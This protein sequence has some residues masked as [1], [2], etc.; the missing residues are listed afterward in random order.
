MLSDRSIYYPLVEIFKVHLLRHLA[1][2]F[3]H[4]VNNNSHI[5]LPINFLYMIKQKA[6]FGGFIFSMFRQITLAKKTD[7]ISWEP[8]FQWQYWCLL[9]S[10]LQ[11]FAYLVSDLSITWIVLIFKCQLNLIFF[12][13]SS[14]DISTISPHEKVCVLSFITNFW[15]T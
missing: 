3:T 12:M 14:L 2:L 8:C 6:V 9:T 1:T 4:V 10:A 13:K 11:I 5:F 7:K 15:T